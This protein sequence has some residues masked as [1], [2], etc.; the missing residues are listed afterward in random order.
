MTFRSNPASG[1]SSVFH[2][3]G[4]VSFFVSW[5]WSAQRS[6]VLLNTGMS[7]QG[8]KSLPHTSLVSE[9]RSS[10]KTV[11]WFS[12]R[13]R[14]TR[15]SWLH[16]LS[17]SSFKNAFKF[18]EWAKRQRSRVLRS[19]R[20]LRAT[21]YWVNSPNSLDSNRPITPSSNLSWYLY[22]LTLIRWRATRGSCL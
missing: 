20:P 3:W 7:A 21:N 22:R 19:P 13:C 10:T 12:R 2:H 14:S 9:C 11:R 15:P 1:F 6:K 18:S 4:F 16:S 5:K 17:L 8:P